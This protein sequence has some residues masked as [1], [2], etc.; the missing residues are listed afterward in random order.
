M[1]IRG[2]QAQTESGRIQT[3]DLCFCCLGDVRLSAADPD[4]L[5]EVLH[6]KLETSGRKLW[7]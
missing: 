1:E 5:V 4:K 7:A 2:P 3:G 6:E